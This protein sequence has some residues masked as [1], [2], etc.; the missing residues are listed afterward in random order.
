MKAYS[1]PYLAEIVSNW[2]IEMS[3]ALM[4]SLCIYFTA[5]AVADIHEDDKKMAALA[6]LSRLLSSISIIIC[7]AEILQV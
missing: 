3:G 5:E 2:R 7:L 6:K 1:R 4:I